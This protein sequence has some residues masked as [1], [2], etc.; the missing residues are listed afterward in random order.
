MTVRFVLHTKSP[1]ALLALLSL[2]VMAL[3]LAAGALAQQN[4]NME[5]EA[6]EQDG[7]QD[8]LCAPPPPQTITTLSAKPF[9]VPPLWDASYE[10]GRKDSVHLAEAL[11]L[12]DG[13]VLVAGT[14]YDA[15]E[16]TGTALPEDGLSHHTPSGLAIAQINPRGRTVMEKRH[17]ARPY[18]KMAAMIRHGEY[19]VTASS[20]READDA[21]YRVR[22]LW[23]DNEGE[24]VREMSLNDPQ[25]SYEAT[26][27][28]PV[29][30]GK[31]FLLH[32]Q[33]TPQQE[34][35]NPHGRIFAYDAKGGALWNR[36]FRPGIPNRIDTIF[37]FGGDGH[38]MAAGQ[39]RMDDGRM[40][41]WVIEL[42]EDG[43]LLRQK[44]HPRGGAAALVTG[45]HMPES[46]GRTEGFIFAGRSTPL[47]G[48]GEAAWI[49][50]TSADGTPE[51][52]RYLRQDGY[53][54]SAKTIRLSADGRMVLMLNAK[55][56]NPQAGDATDRGRHYIR[57][58]TLSP[59]GSIIQDEPYIDAI[60]AEGSGF[61]EGPEGERLI[62]GNIMEKVSAPTADNNGENGEPALSKR[63]IGWV[64]NAT[65]PEPYE[66]PCHDDKDKD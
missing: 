53:N 23:F 42:D 28:V 13:T 36:S 9:G 59:R 18:E 55:A 27:L 29:K 56:R 65:P 17:T 61:R 51:W 63:Q 64:I 54:L 43:A 1:L 38:Y 2:I 19:Y 11:P 21:P 48:S 30:D 46:K 62:L 41:A 66:D 35:A 50:K 10:N 15:S 31:G 37:P 26:G 16:I 58:L 32:T 47:D 4:L 60:H 25:Y 20:Y 49:M 7:T 52:Q 40:A 33:A 44:A 24:K 6:I 39:I 34:P 22:L 5:A 14:L 45:A 12:D 3:T 8:T 57:M